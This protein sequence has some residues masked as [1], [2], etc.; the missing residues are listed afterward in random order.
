MA[1][2]FQDV[3]ATEGSSRRDLVL[4][5]LRDSSEPRTIVDL[6]TE[7]GVHP[8]TVRFHLNSLL[9]A[10]RVERIVGV[11]VGLGR[12]PTT[13][14]AKAGMDPGGP[15]NYRFLAEVLTTRFAQDSHDPATEAQAVGHAWS[16]KMTTSNG[17][18]VRGAKVSATSRGRAIELVAVTL[19]DLGFAPEPVDASSTE[20]RLRHCPF[21]EL[22]PANSN[23]VCSLHLGLMQGAFDALNSSVAVAGLDAFVEPDLCVARLAAKSAA[24]TSDARELM[25]T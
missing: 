16:D 3:P 19:S 21:L 12:P 14:L 13:Y 11:R 22:V 7:L 2:E 5:T 10:G 23:V 25:P 1:T 9:A 20:I 4:K 6:A 8:N 24:A 17:L 18:P 15:T